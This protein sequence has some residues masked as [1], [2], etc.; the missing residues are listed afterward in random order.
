MAGLSVEHVLT[1][2]VRDSAAVLDI[3]SGPGAGDPYGAPTSSQ[4]Y[5]DDVATH[6]EQLRVGVM[7]RAPASLTSL[8]PDVVAAVDET[9]RL[10][11]AAGHF[12]EETHPA[13]L[14][15]PEYL[16]HYGALAATDPAACL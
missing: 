8:H 14:D 7:R 16:L 3:L 4:P 1:R 5:E 13:A 10:L 15:E 2:S 11:E 9:A 6:V 12:V